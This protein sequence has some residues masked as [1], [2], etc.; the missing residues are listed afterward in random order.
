MKERVRM[1]KTTPNSQPKTWT[2]ALRIA[3][4]LAISA[5]QVLLMDAHAEKADRRKAMVL[6]V[7]ESDGDNKA[8]VLNLRKGVTIT[9]GTL[10]IIGDR[11]DLVGEPPKAIAKLFG[12]PVCFRQK[13][14]GSEDIMKGQADRIEYDQSK[15]Q[16]VFLGSVIVHDGTSEMRADHVVYNMGTE[17]FEIR[18][19]AE[20]ADKPVRLV[21]VPREKDEPE[22]VA[23]D[24]TKEAPK[25]KLKTIKEIE[26]GRYEPLA[27]KCTK[28]A[29]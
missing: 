12:A 14:D 18:P 17:K 19:K 4:I 10:K 24:A 25:P 6:D 16:V 11:G 26:L 8:K 20:K 15:E 28:E 5:P 29:L 21:L 22:G 9:Q 13:K 27:S 2:Y 23:V 1:M 3:L 7:G